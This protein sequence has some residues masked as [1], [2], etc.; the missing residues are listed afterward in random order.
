MLLI[1][2]LGLASRLLLF[3]ALL[4]LVVPALSAS[5]GLSAVASAGLG[6]ARGWVRGSL[7]QHELLGSWREL[8]RR[9]RG[10]DIRAL[11]APEN[12]EHAL[13]V[14][15]AAYELA[16]SRV[17]GVPD[18]ISGA[19]LLV[20]VLC[21]AGVRLGWD[22]VFAGCLTMALFAAVLAPARSMIRRSRERAWQASV[23]AGR[24]LETLVGGALELR[25]HRAE[26][27]FV[28][29]LLERA[30]AHAR[31]ERRA[32]RWSALTS[33]LPLVLAGILPL[34]PPQ[35]LVTLAGSRAGEVATLAAAGAAGVVAVLGALASFARVGPLREVV[36]RFGTTSESD[37]QP[38]HDGDENVIAVDVGELSVRHPGSSVSTPYALSFRLT[39]GGAVLLGPN[40]AGKTTAMLAVIGL[41]RPTGGTI[42]FLHAGGGRAASPGQRIACLPQRP[43]AAPEESIAWHLGLFGTTALSPETCERALR[44]VGVWGVLEQRARLAGASPLELR[45]GSLSGGEK[46]RVFL[47]RVLSRDSDLLVL[48]EPEASLDADGRRLLREI[49]EQEAESRMVLL[50]AHDDA[51]IPPGFARIQVERGAVPK[52]ETPDLV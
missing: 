33:A 50:I 29:R 42:S 20:A 23:S 48:D 51:V 12:R 13:Q 31:Q 8:T 3:T 11:A 21:F 18:L 36:E 46:Q 14:V 1:A 22:W 27:R 28:S 32:S 5:V 17:V 52:D 15:D 4:G 49:L 44:R 7:L 34:L 10:K 25:A 40:G 35:L 45:M 26:D 16:V 24:A 37:V 2:V 9:V 6:L 41:L 38:F 19:V 43:H 30:E 39:R 47:A